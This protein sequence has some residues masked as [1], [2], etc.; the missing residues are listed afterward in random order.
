MAANQ[1]IYGP[2]SIYSCFRAKNEQTIPEAGEINRPGQTLT[3]AI[4]VPN[5]IGDILDS[6]SGCS[7]LLWVDDPLAK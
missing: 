1:V 3:M 5:R 7:W 6:F 2:K 4:V